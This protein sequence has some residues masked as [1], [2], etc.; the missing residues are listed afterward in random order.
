MTCTDNQSRNRRLG[1]ALAEGETAQQYMN[2]LGQAVEGFH[3]AQVVH[4]I[5]KENNVEMPICE[6]V[7]KVL[8]GHLELNTAIAELLGRDMKEEFK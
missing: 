1:L 8:N 7:W 4:D 3:A 5:A 6:K 2:E